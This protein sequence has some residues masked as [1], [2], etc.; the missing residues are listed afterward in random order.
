MAERVAAAGETF[1]SYFD[2]EELRGFLATLGCARVEDLGPREI[3]QRFAPDRPLP[4]ENGGHILHAYFP[5][6]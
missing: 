6:R 5:P 3:A 2:T 4:P 1:R